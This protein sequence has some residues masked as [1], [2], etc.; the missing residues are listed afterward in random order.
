MISILGIPTKY[1]LCFVLC[2]NTCM[3][4]NP[5]PAPPKMESP[6]NVFVDNLH[7]LFCAFL[8]STA[9][10][11]NVITFIIKTYL[12]RS[13]FINCFYFLSL[14][15]YSKYTHKDRSP[16]TNRHTDSIIHIIS[17]YADHQGQN[18]AHAKK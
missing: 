3:A 18:T 2:R 1:F 4:T 8:L 12:H 17:Q 6:I 5:P 16:R 15:P 13:I 9:N 7:F 11:R 10:A 14:S